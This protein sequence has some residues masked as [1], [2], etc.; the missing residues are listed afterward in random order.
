[1]HA[2]R[3]YLATPGWG[4]V[5]RQIVYASPW[6]G[7]LPPL[8]FLRSSWPRGGG[9]WVWFSALSCCGS[10]VVAVACLGL[11]P[12]DLPPPPPYVW[13]TNF[14]AVSVSVWPVAC[15]FSS[16]GVHRRVWGVF[17]SGPSAA[18]WSWWVAVSGWASSGWAGWSSA[19]L[20]A[21]PVGVALG[22]AWLGGC[23]PLWSRCGASRLCDSPPRF[24]SSPWPAGVHSWMGGASPFRGGGVVCSSICLPWGSARSDRQRVWLTG[25]LLV[26]WVA[27]GRAPAPWLVW[28]MYAHGRL[29]CPVGLGSGSACWAVAPAGFVRSWVRGNGIVPCPLAPAVSVWWWRV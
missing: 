20:S 26:L 7:F 4:C 15:H 8:F 12:L 6:A 1:M 10:V 2:L 24:S 18:V 19:V 13:D 14:F 29:V 21:G 16:G 27:A 22:V 17:S 25:S 28:V 23:P 5:W 11:G 3:R 9:P